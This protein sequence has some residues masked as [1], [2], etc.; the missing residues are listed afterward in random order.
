MMNYDA[1]LCVTELKVSVV[2]CI[3]F[4]H[5]SMACVNYGCKDMYNLLHNLYSLFLRYLKSLHFFC[6][7]AF[8]IYNIYKLFI[9]I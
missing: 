5:L 9:N 7:F 2:I 8:M 1:Y 3:V 4:S 6:L